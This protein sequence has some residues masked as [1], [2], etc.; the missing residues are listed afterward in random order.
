MT[1][2]NGILD[3]V[4]DLVDRFHLLNLRPQ[5]IACQEQR[6]APDRIDVAVFGRFKAGKSSFLNHLAGRAALPIGVLPLTA[7]I[8]RLRHGPVER[9]AVRFLDGTTK[10][11]P[12]DDLGLYVGENE[13]PHNTRQVAGVEVELPALQSFAPLEFVDTPGLGSAFTHNTEATLHWLPNVGA[14]LVAV[15]ADAPLSERDLNLIDEL[16]RHTPKIAL[17]LTK[18]DLLTESQRAE[19]RDFLRRQLAERWGNDGLPVFFYS[20]K[21]ELPELKTTLVERLLEPLRQDRGAAAQ[22]ILR[23]KL[24]S[25]ISQALD[26]L[27]VA[28][29][30]ATQ[31]ATSRQALHDR[32]LEERGRFDAL[33]EELHLLAH[34]VAGQALEQSV[35]RLQP[36]QRT[37]Q[38]QVIADLEAQLRQW[39]LPLP[40]L[41]EAWRD[42]LN[43]CLKRD[44]NAVSQAQ[45]GMFC[46]P[47]QKARERLT[48]ALRAFQDRLAEHV[49]AALGVTLTPREFALELREPSA[50]PVHVSHAFDAAFTTLGWLIPL[51]LFRPPI[52]RV[53]RRKARWEV[54][55]NLSRL[56]A[57]WQIRVSAGVQELR[58]QA[59]QYALNELATLEQMLA[60]GQSNQ[61]QLEQAIALLT[62][63]LAKMHGPRTE[64]TRP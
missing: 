44:L 20:I 29:A 17:L 56:A 35:Q 45:R 61:P 54:E 10:S 32:L 13:N 41:L 43:D 51:T 3:R 19:V 38:A 58:R 34:D 37:L 28:L 23:H 26:Y 25:L 18:A 31:A 63:A 2:V 11:I 5:I 36:V 47:L 53:L 52:G 49:K 57:D 40:P 24:I 30:A 50:P 7:I 39:R 33:R 22:Q 4:T 8:T 60:Q 62:E 27:R 46:E 15:S 59:E 12:L 42:W 6:A 55:K 64:T 1:R 9:A 48:R 16:R 14:A 21:P